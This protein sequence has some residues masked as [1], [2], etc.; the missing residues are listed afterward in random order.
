MKTINR[1]ARFDYQLFDRYE[2][3]LVLS[4]SEVKA[5]RAG[6]ANISQA[7]TKLIG[8]EIFL[9]NATIQTTSQSANP[10]R[11][12]KLLLHRSEI[13]SIQSQLQAKKLTL[14]PLKLYTKGRLIKLELALARS[15]RKAQKRESIKRKDI[16]R[17]I[18]RELRGRK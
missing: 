15:K 5:I 10:T 14:V 17:D 3:G 1:R 11:T 4:G 9:I 2:A 16:Q 7:H 13:L 18:E 12:R 6:K 8:N